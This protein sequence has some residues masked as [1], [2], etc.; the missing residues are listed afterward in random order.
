M[1][2]FSQGVVERGRK[3][4]N[5]RLHPIT[6]VM[7]TQKRSHNNCTRP[8]SGRST[9]GAHH[10][11]FTVGQRKKIEIIAYIKNES[12]G[13]PIASTV[14]EICTKQSKFDREAFII[15]ACDPHFLIEVYFPT[16]TI[17]RRLDY[18]VIEIAALH[19][20]AAMEVWAETSNC[21]KYCF[22]F[23]TVE[24]GTVIALLW[25]VYSFTS[26][27]ILF[28]QDLVQIRKMLRRDSGRS[29]RS[30]MKPFLF[31]RLVWMV[32]KYK[33]ITLFILERLSSSGPTQKLH[34]TAM[35]SSRA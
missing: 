15:S 34:D 2:H 6:V 9:V 21:F 32:T 4:L 24:T 22:T 30:L 16:I 20:I 23:S 17:H 27:W 14:A 12:S 1:L 25:K 13:P 28:S 29:G 8:Q 26:E 33:F 5:Y 31:L 19:I 11:A 3:T 18:W 10:G 7:R 35:Q